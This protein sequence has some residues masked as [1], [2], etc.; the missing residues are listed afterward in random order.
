MGKGAAI[1]WTP[2]NYGGAESLRGATKSLNNVTSTF[3]NNR[4]A[5]ERPEV[6][7][8]GTKL[9]SCPGRHLTSLSPCA[10]QKLRYPLSK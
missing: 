8:W 5:S 6:R 1:T 9:A 10:A 4:F 7:T 3:F 2:D